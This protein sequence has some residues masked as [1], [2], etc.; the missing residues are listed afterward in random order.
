VLA[1]W[2]EPPSAGLVRIGETKRPDFDFGA[3]FLSEFVPVAFQSRINIEG[4]RKGI[5]GETT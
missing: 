4:S 2:N 3:F 5:K 1:F